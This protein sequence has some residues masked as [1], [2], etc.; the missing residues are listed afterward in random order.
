MGRPLGVVGSAVR[1]PS[2]R[3]RTAHACNMGKP[4]I[5]SSDESAGGTESMSTSSG[6][7]GSGISGAGSLLMVPTAGRTIRTTQG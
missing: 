6:R 4:I 2:L 1:F 5:E 7:D 3:V